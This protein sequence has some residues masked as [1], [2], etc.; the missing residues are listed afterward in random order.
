MYIVY[1]RGEKEREWHLGERL[2]DIEPHRITEIEVDGDEA[3]Y[4]EH[5]MGAIINKP[6]VR[7]Y[8]DLARTVYIN[9]Y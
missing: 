9:L 7:Y 1:D 8:G 2:P 3:K 5:L 4:I 6:V